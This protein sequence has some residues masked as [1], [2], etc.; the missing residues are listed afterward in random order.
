MDFIKGLGGLYYLLIILALTVAFERTIPWRKGLKIDLIRWLRNASM[1]L[2]GTILLSAVP[3]IASYGAAIAAQANGAGLMNMMAM[4]LAIKLILSV[5][6]LDLTAYGQH[7]MLHK[8]YVLWRMHRTHHTD[9]QID[10]STSLRFHPFE[11]LFRALIEVVVVVAI[12]IPPEGI[13]LI[14]LVHVIANCLTHA[15][16]QM[17]LKVEKAMSLVFTSPRMHRLHH[18]ADEAR[19]ATNLGTAFTFWD[20]MF[21]TFLGPEHLRDDERFGVEGPEAMAAETFS[22]MV[23]DP[24]RKPQTGAAPRPDA[25]EKA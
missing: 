11:A 16:V 14:Y 17:P 25:A 5:L 19:Q 23:F 21:G 10:A 22:N 9:P 24:F 13:L 2:Y 8:W 6:V 4:P 3:A 7:R 20:R 18:S 15:N 1:A 12:G